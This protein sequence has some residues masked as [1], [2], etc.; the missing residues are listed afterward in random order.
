MHSKKQEVQKEA[1]KIPTWRDI[2][3]QIDSKLE[4]ELINKKNK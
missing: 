3:K 2:V 1:K 4:D